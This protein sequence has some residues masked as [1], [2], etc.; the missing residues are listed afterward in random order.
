MT[1]IKLQSPYFF[2]LDVD[3]PAKALQLANETRAFVGGFKIGPRLVL[4]GGPS[5]VK[6]LAE[7]APVF[8]DMKFFDIPS[9]MVAAVRA[10]FEQGASFA[11]IHAACGNEA[12]AQLAMLER[13]L[14]QQRPFTILA[15]TIL[16]SFKPETLPTFVRQIPIAEQ[17]RQLA[18]EVQTAGLRGLVCSPHETAEL[19]RLWPQS[20]LVTP[21]IR[22]PGDPADDQSRTLEPR[23]ALDSGASALVI[24]RPLLKAAKP[25]QKAQE[26][27]RLLE[28][29]NI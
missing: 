14:N 26:I 23:A 11:T 19:R 12:L 28:E 20:Y 9:T 3:E 2:A 25:A 24:G 7:L 22:L 21:G 16:T 8:L 6:A 29:K 27:F 18:G 5:L 15:V 10:G 13:E 4:R 1:P 17:V